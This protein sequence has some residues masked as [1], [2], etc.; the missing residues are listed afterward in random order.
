[1]FLWVWW[2]SCVSRAFCTGSILTRHRAVQC[3]RVI[4]LSAYSAWLTAVHRSYAGTWLDDL[5]AI[6]SLPLSANCSDQI[7]TILCSATY[8]R[9]QHGTARIRPPHTAAVASIDQSIINSCIFRVVQVIK[10]LHDPLKVENNLPGI[11]DN[12]RERGLE[13]KCF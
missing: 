2:G 7:K 3:G 9:W 10:S 13:Q 8:V 5:T 1:M 4:S 11:N 6:V 12:V